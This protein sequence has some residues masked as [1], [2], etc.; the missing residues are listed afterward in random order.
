V[1][2]PGVIT[3]LATR[4]VIEGKRLTEL[5]ISHARFFTEPRVMT[6]LAPEYEPGEVR[7]SVRVW[8]RSADAGPLPLP[9]RRRAETEHGTEEA[10]EAREAEADAV[11]PDAP[12]L[13]GIA[14]PAKAAQVHAEP[15]EQLYTPAKTGG[16]AR[17]A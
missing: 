2:Q 12:P 4:P 5:L 11:V 7:V 16:Y 9:R 6:R 13:R 15:L 14:G 3:V 17:G 8:H 1:V 10:H